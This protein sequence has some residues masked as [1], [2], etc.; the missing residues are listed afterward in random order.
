[1]AAAIWSTPVASA[2][3]GGK[4]RYAAKITGYFEGQ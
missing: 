2:I 1:M 3:S 4:L